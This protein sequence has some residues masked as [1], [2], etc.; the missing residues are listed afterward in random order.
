MALQPIPDDFQNIS[1]A[2]IYIADGEKLA[3]VQIIDGRKSHRI[4]MFPLAEI[5]VFRTRLP[6]IIVG[7]HTKSNLVIDL[8]R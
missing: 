3:E 2:P 5:L 6:K 8:S 7:L 4:S 1:I